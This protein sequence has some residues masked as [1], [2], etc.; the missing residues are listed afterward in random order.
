MYKPASSTYM[1]ISISIWIMKSCTDLR[2][3]NKSYDTL[4]RREQ[5]KTDM[6]FG[7]WNVRSLYRAGSL[8]SAARE[9]VTYIR[10]SGCAGG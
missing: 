6:R 8:T 3:E 2:K 5:R 7:R 1:T 4:V 10:F 9:L